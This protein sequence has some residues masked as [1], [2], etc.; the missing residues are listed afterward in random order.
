MDLDSKTLEDDYR[1]W[2]AD[3]KDKAKFF[4]KVW[5]HIAM[6]EQPTPNKSRKF[7]HELQP[8]LPSSY[9]VGIDESIDN[10]S[11]VVFQEAI[12]QLNDEAGNNPWRNKND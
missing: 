3:Q 2:L 12:E 5:A 8:E 6:E 9:V 10:L 7:L 4:A 1:I 11:R